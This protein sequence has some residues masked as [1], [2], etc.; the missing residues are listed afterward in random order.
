MAAEPTPS[1][2]SEQQAL[3]PTW[4]YKAGAWLRRED[5]A[6]EDW[7]THNP[8]HV[9][10][11]SA[12]EH[13]RLRQEIEDYPSRALRADEIRILWL[14]PGAWHEEIACSLGPVVLAD[15][16]PFE[17][18]SYTWGLSQKQRTIWLKGMD[19]FSVTD[20]AF[21][22]LRRLRRTDCVRALWI[23]AICIC[24]ADRAEREQQ[25]SM[26]GDIYKAA[27]RCLV[28]LGEVDGSPTELASDDDT[29]YRPRDGPDR[30]GVLQALEA[31]YKRVPAFA[32][33]K[34][35]WWDRAWVMHEVAVA[36]EVLVHFGPFRL[37]WGK[38]CWDLLRVASFE[39]PRDERASADQYP[40]LLGASKDFPVR[41]DM[42]DGFYRLDTVRG[43][44]VKRHSPGH[45]PMSLQAV[46]R[47]ARDLGCSD[48]RDKIYSSFSLVGPQASALLPPL[49]NITWVEVFAKATYASIVTEKDYWIWLL[50]DTESRVFRP[51]WTIDFSRNG[52][53]DDLTTMTRIGD[54][55]EDRV[56]WMGA[57]HVP[58]V[59]MSDNAA[60][61]TVKGYAFDT[62]EH[63][64]NL[65]SNYGG[66]YRHHIT[67]ELL[68]M[69]QKALSRKDVHRAYENVGDM[70]SSV[71]NATEDASR[72][73]WETQS[74]TA[75]HE[76]HVEDDTEQ[77]TTNPTSQDDLDTCLHAKIPWSVSKAIKQA[78][79]HWNRLANL[80][81]D[82]SVHAQD[83]RSPGTLFWDLERFWRY[84]DAC[85][86]GARFITTRAG[87]LGL[88]PFTV[89]TGSLIVLLDGSNLPVFLRGKGGGVYE[90]GGFVYVHGIMYGE[91]LRLGRCRGLERQSF[92]IV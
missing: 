74:A 60:V 7:L 10:L 11:L 16:P 76:D 87:F 57:P 37:P 41:Q 24:Q 1:D 32:T 34:L 45:E 40:Q 54:V 30:S 8:G 25:V 49:Y 13:E 64:H 31:I 92:R 83:P 17:A 50:K 42:A 5:E 28:W 78:W 69:L 85:S 61:L 22:V 47:T 12:L 44:Y 53:Q 89:R 82:T 14:K 38:F 2:G 86:R 81:P 3:M 48:Y 6:P 51:S 75:N 23:D 26:M 72:T 29:S 56:G 77:P 70:S 4:M 67:A 80:P 46:L 66:G 84:A 68:T 19:S 21:D 36:R 52:P 43:N 39:G 88:A 9:K 79:N 58:D 59:S 90:F 18:V 15:A 91:L 27:E 65:P 71:S 20:N 35:H 73:A 63:T 62:I 55:S 33:F